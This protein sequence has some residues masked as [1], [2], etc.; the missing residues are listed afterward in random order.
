[1]KINLA[2]IKFQKIQLNHEI[3]V[4]LGRSSCIVNLHIMVLSI[5]KRKM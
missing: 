3:T 1:M 2:L 5:K 4:D